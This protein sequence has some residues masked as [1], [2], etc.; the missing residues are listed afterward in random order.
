MI[1]RSAGRLRG[2]HIDQD[3]EQVLG[4]IADDQGR[5]EQVR[6]WFRRPGYVPESLFYLFAGRP[7]RILISSMEERVAALWPQSDTPVRERH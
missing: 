3:T 2:A 5:G 7:E 1:S 6:N 4:E